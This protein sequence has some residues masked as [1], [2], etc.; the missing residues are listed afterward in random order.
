MTEQRYQEF[1]L[2]SDD[3]LQLYG[4]DYRSESTRTLPIVCL[5]GLSRNSRDFHP[6]ALRLME[7]GHR[8]V[9]LDYRGRGRSDW[10]VDKANYNVVREAQDVV[11]ALDHLGIERAQ[12][13]GTSRGGLILHILAATALDRIAGIILNDIGPEIES[14]GLQRIRDYLS[15]RSEFSSLAEAASA[16]KI[17][18]GAEFPALSADDWLEMAYALYRQAGG[19]WIADFDPALVELLKT[20]DFS[21]KLPDLWP[22][23]AAMANLPVLVVRGENSRLLSRETATEMLKRHPGAKLLTVTGQ[24]HAPLLHFNEVYAPFTEFLNSM[25]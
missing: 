16:L 24:G 5:A 22:Q 1:H 9:T 21:K 13:I 17:I 11:A 23:Y 19:I 14:D 6:L 20:M 18:H 7:D 8:V 10:D 12:F 4:R 2:T 25:R 3:G 15:K